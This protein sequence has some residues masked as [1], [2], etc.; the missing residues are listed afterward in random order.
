MP[1]RIIIKEITEGTIALGEDVDFRVERFFK[2]SNEME[3]NISN[4]G[5]HS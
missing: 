3:T 4:L 2:A 5:S 1:G